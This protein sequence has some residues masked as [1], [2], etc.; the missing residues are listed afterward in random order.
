MNVR[1]FFDTNIF[2]YSFDTREPH[3]ADI[4]LRLILEHAE[5]GTGVISFQV[6]REFFS[7]ALR[8]FPQVMQPADR[9]RYLTMVLQPFLSVYGSV[10]LCLK[11]LA[12]R[13][14]Y[15]YQWYDS[16][17]IA[18][19]CESKCSILFSEDLQHGQ[20]IDGVRIPNPFLNS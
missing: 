18:A 12:I 10:S 11:A 15:G 3:K 7:V 19:A 20:I 8:R 17:I 13:S 5:A 16:L 1:A 2:V 4:A 9:E 6:V 14:R